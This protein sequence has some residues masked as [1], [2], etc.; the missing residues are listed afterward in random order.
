MHLVWA[1]LNQ[2]EH[3]LNTLTSLNGKSR[4]RLLKTKSKRRTGSRTWIGST[5]RHKFDE[6]WCTLF[7][8]ESLVQVTLIG[9]LV[10]EVLLLGNM[11]LWGSELDGHVVDTLFW[12]K[13]RWMVVSR[14]RAEHTS[15]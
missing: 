7:M 10:Q 3:K 4:T 9:C 8:A 13:D 1:K 5:A 2:Y 15:L 11:A 12:E 6:M 14:R